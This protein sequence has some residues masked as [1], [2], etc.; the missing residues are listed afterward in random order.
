MSTPIR[1]KRSAV[2]GKRPTVDQ[3]QLGELAL[4]FW[5][6]KLFVKRE[7]N[8]GQNVVEIGNLLSRVEVTGISTLTGR[9]I[10][11]DGARFG[12][13]RLS[14]TDNVIDTTTGDLNLTPESGIVNKLSSRAYHSFVGS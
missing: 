4:N 14:I 8:F 1:L 6:G 5:D 11:E 7:D 13:V 12:N 2:A 10:N 3:I 9:I